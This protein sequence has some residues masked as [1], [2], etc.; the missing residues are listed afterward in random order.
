MITLNL[1]PAKCVTYVHY[2]RLQNWPLLFIKPRLKIAENIIIVSLILYVQELYLRSLL[3]FYYTF[4]HFFVLSCRRGFSISL[5][6]E[7]CC[8]LNLTISLANK[9]ICTLIDLHVIRGASAVFY[10][11]YRIPLPSVVAWHSFPAFSTVE[12]VD[13]MK[14]VVAKF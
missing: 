12:E 13:S 8:S 9:F 6:I 4:V 7:K 3:R 10:K 2:W 1:S 11:L 14:N 5:K